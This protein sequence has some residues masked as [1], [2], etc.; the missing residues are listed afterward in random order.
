MPSFGWW[1]G[2]VILAL[3]LVLVS[4][5]GHG[6][7][8]LD[9]ELPHED[10]ES[11]DQVWQRQMGVRFP[12]QPDPELRTFTPT[13]APL[14]IFVLTRGQNEQ[15]KDDP[16]EA[17]LADAVSVVLRGAGHTVESMHVDALAQKMAQQPGTKQYD[18]AI[19][20]GGITQEELDAL[21]A[22]GTKVAVL[23]FRNTFDAVG[24]KIIY[25]VNTTTGMF[26]AQGYDA[27]IA[28]PQTL[29]VIH[30]LQLAYGTMVAFKA[31]TIWSPTYFRNTI[32][33]EDRLFYSAKEPSDKMVSTF[34]ENR[35][36]TDNA[37]L[38]MSIIEL[39]FRQAP[40]SFKSA[41]I[42]SASHLTTQKHMKNFVLNSL[43]V[44][45]ASKMTFEQQYDTPWFLSHY[46]DVVLA[47]QIDDYPA[48]YMFEALYGGFPLVHNHPELKDC[49]Y[50]FEDLDG[51][52]AV[53]Q[54]EIALTHHDSSMDRY[55]QQARQCVKKVL[56]TTIEN[57]KTWSA[58][59]SQ[60]MS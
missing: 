52:T 42:T 50:Y 58:I 39:L 16:R 38:A 4:V 48:D 44:Y 29:R 36:L 57:I 21:H 19:D 1:I 18:A 35:H 3:C 24:E 45:K 7:D 60:L 54:L 31:P 49:G 37:A 9:V 56:P 6:A 14:N 28:F 34:H 32:G 11:L 22:V 26:Q 59:I 33:G 2:G 51:T 15:G 47:A 41:Y 43:L 12:G 46:T 8:D 25:E 27:I 53:H 20:M 10:V 13:A 30:F 23:P 5:T 55:N 40:E 17:Q